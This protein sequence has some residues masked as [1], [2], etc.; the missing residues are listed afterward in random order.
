MIIE[1]DG[2]ILSVK[3]FEERYLVTHCF[4]RQNG[5]M[6]GIVRRSK[7][8]KTDCVPGNIVHATWKAR[9]REQLGHYQFD[10]QKNTFA[11]V[12]FY[13]LTLALFRS[14]LAMTHIVLHEKERQIELF[15]IL[16]DFLLSVHHDDPGLLYK[17]Y[18]GLE[19]CILKTS[20]FGLSLDKCAVTGTVENLSYISPKSGAIVTNEVGVCYSDKVIKAPT[21]LLNHVQSITLTEMLQCLN[22]TSFFIEK[23]ILNNLGKK[24]PF[25]R[26][27]LLELLV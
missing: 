25:A 18:V 10:L 8:T 27:S 15:D 17:K 9:L 2:I 7:S 19:L 26:S 16:Q 13:R 4:L 24:M 14:A 5:L 20:G 21:G 11:S 1:D 6:A 3:E 12:I 22:V 23:N